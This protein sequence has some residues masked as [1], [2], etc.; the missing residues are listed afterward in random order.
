MGYVYAALWFIVGMILVFKMGK[1]NK[2][3]FAVGGFFF[4]WGVWQTLNEV[5]A[6]DMYSGIYGWIHKGVRN[7]QSSKTNDS[8]KS[9]KE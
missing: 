1:E 2:A 6:I 3:F 7:S 5:L 9:D 8:E 4:F